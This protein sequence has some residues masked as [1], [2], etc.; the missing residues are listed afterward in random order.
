MHRAVASDARLSLVIVEGF[1]DCMN[2]WQ[3][4]HERVVALMGSSLS[5]AQEELIL[6]VA[7]PGGRV[8]LMLD[9]DEAGR[10]AR[11]DIEAR[12]SRWLSVS[13]VR[14]GEGTQPDQLPIEVIQD[15]L[16]CT[17]ANE[18]SLHGSPD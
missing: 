7:G 3:A 9:E 14:F 6:K 10:K 5:Q 8:V 4:G 15:L 12:L 18:R 2:I 1:F 11:V 17:V 13:V 16:Q